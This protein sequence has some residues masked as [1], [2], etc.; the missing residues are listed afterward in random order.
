MMTALPTEL[1]GRRI[2]VVDVEGNGHQPPEIIEIAILALDRDINTTNLS[3]WLIRPAQPI[4][5]IVTRKVH[6]IRNTDVAACP[7]W[8]DVAEKVT[9]A[10]T[11]RVIVAHNATVE[12]RVLSAHLPDWKPP[13]LLDT[14]RL[15]KHVWPGLAGYSLDRLITH[16]ELP[17]HD[18]PGKRHRAGYDTWMT[19][20]LLAVLVEQ[21]DLSWNDVVD[22]AALPGSSPSET[23]QEALW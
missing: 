17:D 20:H 6:G 7:A 16:A 10:L 13:M 3:T 21:A 8:P 9:E 23:A 5:A 14:M 1:T 12:Q 19:A 2:T 22:I 4:T 18:A 11:D 15:A